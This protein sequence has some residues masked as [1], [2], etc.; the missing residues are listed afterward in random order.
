MS[1]EL[2]TAA[3]GS[4]RSPALV[5]CAALNRREEIGMWNSLRL[6]RSALVIA[7]AA[8]VAAPTIASAQDQV[9]AADRTKAEAEA[10]AQAIERNTRENARQLTLYDKEGKVVATVGDRGLYNQPVL[11]PDAT[12]VAVIKADL[13]KETNDLWIV[14]IASGRGTQITTSKSREPV[15]APAWSPDAKYVGY[16]GLRGSRYGIYR[17]LTTGEGDEELIYQHAGGPIVLTDWSL[18]GKVLSFYASDL[19]G[20]TLYLVPVDGDRKPVEVTHSESQVVAARLSPDGR[21][22]AYRSNEKDNRDQIFVRA[23]PAPGASKDAPVG[24]WQ[25]STDGGEGMVWWRRDGKELYYIGP[26]RSVMAVE[27]R[28]GQDFEFSKPRLLF[29]APASI[30]ATGNPGAFG[31]VSRNGERV[32]FVVP[33]G[34]P[35]RQLTIFDRTGKVIRKVGEPG[36]YNQPSMSPD[37][38]KIVAMRVDQQTDL[39]D[40]WTYDVASGK[41]T[42]VTSTREGENAPIWL[43]DGQRIAYVTARGNV[44]TASIY[45]KAATGQGTEEQLFRYTPGAGMVLTDF[46]ADGKFL[47]FDG[48]GIILVVPLSGDD[49]L[50]R[51][52]VDFAR[53]EYE[54]GLGRFSPDGKFLAYGSNET[55]RFEVFVRPFDASSASAAGEQKWKISGDGAMG[56]ITWSRDG[57]ELYYLSEERSTQEIK[58]MAVE[59]KTSP[60]F[61]A[62]AP[63]VLFRLKGPLPGNP[64]QWKI[65]PDGQQF[66]FAVPVEAVGTK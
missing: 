36:I 53:S 21:W 11:S 17:K 55:G 13:A 48:G 15:Q 65:S 30:P 3:A 66:V 40:I 12:R 52:G 45:R 61:G 42:A 25:V 20:S 22:L 6:V 60:S 47:T 38:S 39:T 8:A 7:W 63:K 62:S 58:V 10:R 59:I 28:A 56:G 4:T 27:V 32:V 29:K 5:R 18:D 19:S 33:P 64:G 14:D 24:K 37:G 57:R 34:Q 16:V 35:L 26:E 44:N 1:A 31:S 2:L 23:V 50:K 49:A 9:S 54:A 51:Q 46:S 41:G 43:P